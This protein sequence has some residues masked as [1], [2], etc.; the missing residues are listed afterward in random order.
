MNEKIIRMYFNSSH[1]IKTIS[2]F[3]N[4]KTSDVG[5]II[6]RYKKKHHIR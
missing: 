1:S 4:M 2:R 6:L 5:K 3:F